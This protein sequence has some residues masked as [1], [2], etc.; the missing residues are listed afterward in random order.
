MKPL[1]LAE[2]S[3]LYG[4]VCIPEHV[5]Q[6]I[7]WRG[8]FH[9][10]D[11]RT[12]SGKALRCVKPGRWNKQEG[13]DFIGASLEIDGRLVQGDVEVHFY[14]TDWQAHGHNDDPAFD[15]VVL[16][17]LLFPP[18]NGAPPSTRSG[19]TPEM[20]VLL[21]HL[22]EDL[23]DYAEREALLALESR[24]KSGLCT[25]LLAHPEEQRLPLLRAK[26]AGRWR[27]K[28][29]FALQR[30]EA[31][32]WEN[33]CHQLALE[34]LGL[35]RNRAPMSALA[36]SH[37]PGAMRTMDAAALFEEHRERWHL[38]GLRP[39][40]H[41]LRRLQQYLSLLDARPDWAARL[42][43]WGAGLQVD[44]GVAAPGVETARFRKAVHFSGIASRLQDELLNGAIGGTRFHT[45]VVDAL[46]PL[47][48]AQ[49][50]AP[51]ACA[52]YW[53]HWHLGDA[54]ANLHGLCAQLPQVD[55]RAPVLCNG[56]F[57]GLLQLSYELG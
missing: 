48:A 52:R 26:A 50:V 5:L 21:A 30:L 23:E 31:H 46:L 34:T 47:L 51:D 43:E 27:Q 2:I 40:N 17:V 13:P 45:L 15:N 29:R 16:H 37:P 22:N 11:M 24:D 55:V 36:Q 33:A 32:G 6:K 49:G 53:Y 9:Q 54:P 12:L 19:R 41:P 25:A 7:W 35:K 57:Q 38:A 39:A 3:G 44:A 8:D 14:S 10:E 42:I 1:L 56:L 20:F 28:V 4:P 18:R